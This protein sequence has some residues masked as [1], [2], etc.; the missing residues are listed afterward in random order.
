MLPSINL[1][2]SKFP[3]QNQQ[4]HLSR[5][6]R[7]KLKYRTRSIVGRKPRMILHVKSERS[8]LRATATSTAT[9]IQPKSNHP[10][11]KK[12]GARPNAKTTQLALNLRLKDPS[13]V[14]FMLL[15]IHINLNRFSKRRCLVRRKQKLASPAASPQRRIRFIVAFIDQPNHDSGI[16]WLL[17]HVLAFASFYVP[18]TLR[19]CP[20]K[21]YRPYKL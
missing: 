14:Q 3:G 12:S 16:K 20:S 19:R 1:R 15:T 5:N 13:I 11:L 4:S 8:S 6:R 17:R 18:V 9:M 2:P 10:R 7:Q 21:L